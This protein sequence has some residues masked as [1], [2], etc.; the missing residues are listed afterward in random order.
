MGSS[1]GRFVSCALGAVVLAL[2]GCKHPAPPDG[3]KVIVGVQ[4][5][6]MGGIVSAL[7]IVVRVAGDVVD[8]ETLSPPHGSRVGFPQPWEKA[9]SGEGKG[10]AKVEVAVEALGGPGQ[11]PLITRLASTQFVPGKVSLLR[12]QLESRCVVYP[13]PRP[14]ARFPGPLSGPVCAA[15]RRASTGSAIRLTFRRGGLEPYATNWPRR[16]RRRCRP[17]EWRARRADGDRPVLLLAPA[18]VRRSKPRRG[19]KAVTTSGSRRG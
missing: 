13:P 8:D 19:R 14:E 11:P 2:A 5:E 10:T 18:R 3:T 7:H 9:I 6:P 15:P 12:V 4:S 17:V 16:T 1:L